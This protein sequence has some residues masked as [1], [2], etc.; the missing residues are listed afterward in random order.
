MI[1]ITLNSKLYFMV[2]G[3]GVRI[4]AL[5]TSCLLLIWKGEIHLTVDCLSKTCY[6]TSAQSGWRNCVGRLVSQWN[7]KIYS[8]SA[9]NKLIRRGL[10]DAGQGQ[11]G[12]RDSA[13]T[14]IDPGVWN[15]LMVSRGIQPLC[16]QYFGVAAKESPCFQPHG[17]YRAGEGYWW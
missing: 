1:I 9:P 3:S 8:M 7:M 10:L 17:L 15:I 14:Y 2:L 13:L 12:E 11:P 5:C 4:P 16:S 6:T